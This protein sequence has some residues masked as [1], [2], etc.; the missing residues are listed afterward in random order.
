M[1]RRLLMLSSG[2]YNSTLTIRLRYLARHLASTWN[3]VIIA[4][5]ADKYND[6]RPDYTLRPTFARLI[7]PWQLT[8]QSFMVNLIP[9]L[10][11][12]LTQI[13]RA[14]ADLIVIYKPTPITVLG[15][16]PKVLV[17]T[18]I[19][20][21]LD[22]LG[23][24]VIRDEGR[25]WLTYRL[26]DWSE[27][28]CIRYA[29]MVVVVSTALRDHVL[30]VH[31]GKRVLLLPNG[32]EP[33]EY[34][35]V[36]EQQPRRAVYY[37]GAF[38]G[39]DLVRDLLE[40][41]PGVLRQVPDARLT[42]VGGGDALDDAKRLSRELGIEAAVAFPGWQ[43]DMLA[44]QN[45]VQFADVGVCYMP[46]VRT[47]RA[48]SNMKVF[49]YMAMGTVPLVSDVGD[50]RR[51]VRDGEVGRVVAPGDVQE[52][53]RALVELL[54]DDEYRVRIAKEAWRL[55]CADYSWQAH[56]ETLAT[57]LAAC[58]ALQVRYVENPHPLRLTRQVNRMFSHSARRLLLLGG[59]LGMVA[60]SACAEGTGSASKPASNAAGGSTTATAA[61]AMA[62]TP[63]IATDSASSGATAG[64]P[65]ASPS[66]ALSRVHVPVPAAA[67][68]GPTVFGFAAPE[69]LSDNQSTQVEQLKQM[70]SMGVTSVRVDADWYW[71][72]LNGPDSF[73]WT[74][75][76]QV[77]ASL[78]Q[79]GLSADFVIDGCPPWAAVAGAQGQEFAQPASSAA[80]AKWAAEVAARYGPK[81]V[82]K[83][84]EIWNE[85]NISRFWLP[86]PDVAAYT[87]D[88]IAAYSAI[89][90]VD[91]SA[92]VISAGLSDAA[93]TSTSYD[94]RTFLQD[95]YA[96]GAKG[97][98]DGVGDHPYSYPA[99]PDNGLSGWSQMSQTSP[100][101]R[102]IM[103][104][105]GDSAKKIWI[106]EYGAPTTGSDS[107]SESDQSTELV[108]AISQAKQLSWIGS[109]YIYTWSDVSSGPSVDNGFGLLT[110]TNSQKP[111]YAAV[112]AAL[113]K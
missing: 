36:A 46:D 88:L 77:V 41:M 112:N 30:R 96:D 12:S 95:M 98:F 76:D 69:V 10:F 108:Q 18:P 49:Q 27:R 37:F 89:K 61:P 34:R 104:E 40:A 109:F 55:A 52:L 73:D 85:P 56:A 106:T 70:K 111:A 78:Q 31:P 39:L 75:L 103:V 3:I 58:Q 24:E 6:F 15:L 105:H 87:E 33:G 62:A 44:V 38:N 93:D 26:V 53:T 100:S 29:D 23:G 92:V 63:I 14:R 35:V 82:V 32:V 60:L 68:S 1:K 43:A 16:V 20:L 99:S 91:P 102:S 47:V 50:L 11:T 90:A 86:K 48:A 25:S 94:P 110:D 101:L 5:S 72:Q 81:G 59:I 79:V 9:Y 97:S 28:L 4:P 19:V 54:Q 65:S 107:V 57:E 2:S 71:A 64:H 17:R 8:T 84:F 67:I 51:Y 42:I 74:S 83:F 66:G 13:L 7:Q 22:D 21:D 80:F 45:Y 113:A